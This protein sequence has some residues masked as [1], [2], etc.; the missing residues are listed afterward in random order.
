MCT[1]ARVCAYVRMCVWYARQR[2]AGRPIAITGAGQDFATLL[3]VALVFSC[4]LKVFEGRKPGPSRMPQAPNPSRPEP[5]SRT[6]QSEPHQNTSSEA[7]AQAE[8][9][10]LPQPQQPS[11]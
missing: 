1:Y 4:M 3:A 11:P 9:T 6:P 10:E 2:S 7:E 5:R 8:D